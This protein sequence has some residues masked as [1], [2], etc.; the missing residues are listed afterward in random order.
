MENIARNAVFLDVMPGGYCKNV[1]FGRME[2]LH[3]ESGKT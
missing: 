1:R 3:H 2:R